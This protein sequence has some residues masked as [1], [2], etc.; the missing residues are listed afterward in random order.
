MSAVKI[1][2]SLMC[3][4]LIRLG[5][6]LDVMREEGIEYLHVDVMD[7]HYVPNLS[8]GPGFCRSVRGHSPIALDIHLMVDNPDEILP[9]FSGIAD[10]VISFH[11]EAVWHPLRTVQAIRG[12]GARPGIC[13]DPALP[14]SAVAELLPHV[15]LVCVMTVSPGYAGERLIPEALAKI[16]TVADA[17]AGRPVEVEVDGNVSWL[18][19][20]RMVAEGAGVLVAGS[21][22]LYDGAAGLRENIR[23]LR[24]LAGRG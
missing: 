11:P 16:R 5:A 21:S 23:R 22:S 14:V 17:V 12:L 24:A 18:H 8:L 20:P 7:G 2:P 1:A 10:A 13:I 9:R 6:E 15:D 4:D 19:A 3:A